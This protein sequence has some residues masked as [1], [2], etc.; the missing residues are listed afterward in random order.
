MSVKAFIAVALL[1]APLAVFAC[2]G[3]ESKMHLGQVVNIDAK[4]RTFTI[5]DA[6]TSRPVT[7]KAND[8]VMAGV[9]K[10]SG[11]VQVNFE[12]NADGALN[13]VGVTF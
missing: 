12:E 9:K 10:A 1:S 11:T 2:G 13:A 7:F 8:E 5:R 4:A 3:K 6:E